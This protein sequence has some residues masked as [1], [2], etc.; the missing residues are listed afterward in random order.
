MVFF[1]RSD[2]LVKLG[3]AFAIYLLSAFELLGYWRYIN[4][5]LLFIIIIYYYLLPLGIFLPHFSEKKNYLVLAIHWFGI[6]L[7]E[8]T[9]SGEKHKPLTMRP[10]R[11]LGRC[12]SSFAYSKYKPVLL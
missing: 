12:T 4:I 9:L 10:N 1:A 7:I 2:W 11:F 5:L 6:H 3:I 8:K